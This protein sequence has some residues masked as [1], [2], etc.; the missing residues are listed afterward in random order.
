MK[1]ISFNV[2]DASID[3]QGIEDFIQSH[4]NTDIWCLQEAFK[5]PYSE[6]SDHLPMI[7]KI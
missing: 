7:L 1:L 3:P 4:K 5:V 2:N 6:I